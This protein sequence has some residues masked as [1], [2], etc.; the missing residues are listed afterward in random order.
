[1]LR[2]LFYKKGKSLSN[3]SHLCAR[4]FR[5]KSWHTLANP[6]AR[7]KVVLSTSFLRCASLESLV[8]TRGALGLFETRICD[9]LYPF[10]PNQFKVFSKNDILQV[11]LSLLSV[12]KTALKKNL[13]VVAPG[14]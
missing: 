5:L 11:G 3:P 12:T 6:W 10:G 4:P 8:R 7:I 1:M 2:S 13:F 14:I 9:F